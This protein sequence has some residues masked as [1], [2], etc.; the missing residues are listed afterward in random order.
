MIV[1]IVLIHLYSTL[2]KMTVAYATVVT[3][4]KTV[5]VIASAQ[6]QTIVAAYVLVVTPVIQLTVIRIVTVIVSALLK[7]IVAAYVLV[8]TPVIQLIVIK[9]VLENVLVMTT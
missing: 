3:L 4:I 2:V 1:V 9:I 7:M 6:L 8:V 5:M